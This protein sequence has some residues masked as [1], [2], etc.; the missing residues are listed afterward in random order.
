MGNKKLMGTFS[1]L[2]TTD[3]LVMLGVNSSFQQSETHRIQ[4]A[5]RSYLRL[6]YSPPTETKVPKSKNDEALR[7]QPL[8]TKVR[9][10]STKT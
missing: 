7:I 4:D 1:Q 6:S 10:H 9:K 2:S 5:E 3:L 8:Q